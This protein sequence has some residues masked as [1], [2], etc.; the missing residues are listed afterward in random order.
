MQ[1]LIA[2]LARRL[3][4]LE[5]ENRVLAARV[6]ELEGGGTGA[7]APGGSAPIGTQAHADVGGG[8]V[9]S[10][11]G[12]LRHL[13]TA[14]AAV[15]GTVVGASMLGTEH[16]AAASGGDLV[17]GAFNDADADG[18]TLTSSTDSVTFSAYN[19]NSLGTAALWG[20]MSAA[21]SVGSG[22]Y[23][24][25][26]GSGAAVKGE[27]G[28]TGS[29][30]AMHGVSYGT[31]SAV[32]ASCESEDNSAP[33]IVANHIGTGVG[34][35][36]TSYGDGVSVDVVD[37][38]GHGAKLE[39][40][41]SGTGAFVSQQGTGKGMVVGVTGAGNANPGI[42]VNHLGLGRGVDV[43][44]TNNASAAH[45]VLATTA[46][47]GRAL[48]GRTSG[49]GNAIYGYVANS[50]NTQAAVL[51][52]TT[53]TGAAVEATSTKG[54]GGKFT[55]KAAQVRLVPSAASNHPATGARGDLFVDKSGRLWF[56]KGGSSWKQ[57]A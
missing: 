45:A 50:S 35:Q 51:A 33:A 31:G 52:S 32:L 10:R 24:Q 14:A 4:Q 12:L 54:V 27:V 53:G 55:G 29:A 47:L 3:E 39:V 13:G 49:T 19:S 16:A 8:E 56:C 28:D 21:D 1:E 9:V 7:A 25:T 57:L 30:V 22:V 11:R 41:G 38:T 40:K 26:V 48:Y 37:G 42:D 34:V 2:D 36:V 15:G 17:L 46:G 5:D 44:L 43:A 23:G 20:E 18:T 6:R